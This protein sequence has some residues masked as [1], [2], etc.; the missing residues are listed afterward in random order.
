MRGW[1]DSGLW[2]RQWSTRTENRVVV[3]ASFPL[4]RSHPQPED[5]GPSSKTQGF[6]RF[7]TQLCRA[8]AGGGLATQLDAPRDRPAPSRRAALGGWTA[9]PLFKGADVLPPPGPRGAASLPPALGALRSARTAA[10]PASALRGESYSSLGKRPE[11]REWRARWK[12][13]LSGKD[14]ASRGVG[15]TMTLL[16]RR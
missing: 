10:L 7:G 9:A 6:L 8:P 3:L 14:G 1:L 16:P 4:P 13:E 2:G 15:V 11:R 5:N 12:G